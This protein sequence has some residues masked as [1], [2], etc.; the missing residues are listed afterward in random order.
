M[1]ITTPD[2]LTKAKILPPGIRIHL[3]VTNHGDCDYKAIFNFCLPLGTI[4]EEYRD[5][6][7]NSKATLKCHYSIVNTE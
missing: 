1:K 5:S 4:S 3:L 6:N 2:S 7:V